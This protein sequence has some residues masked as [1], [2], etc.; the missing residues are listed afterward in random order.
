MTITTTDGVRLD[1]ARR[2]T[3]PPLVL[4]HGGLATRRC[5]DA[6]EPALAGHFQTVA[7]DRRGTGASDHAEDRSLAREARDLAEVVAAVGGPVDVLAYSYGGLI[8]LHAM[9]HEALPVRRAFLYEPPLGVTGMAPGTLAADVTA[10]VAEGRFD[11]AC[12]RFVRGALSLSE[13]T[14]ERMACTPLWTEAVDTVPT[15]PGEIEAVVASRAE[16]YG[17]IDAR[18]RV[19]VQ[20]NGGNPAFREVAERLAAALPNADTESIDSVPHFAMASHPEAFT[21]PALAFL[22][23]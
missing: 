6:V 11:E 20:R 19:L 14:V 4:V 3:G 10:L 7:Y 13:R 9:A 5:F 17:R 15:L 12:R 22:T 18:V 21:A 1:C 8:A 2:G 16:D 23:G